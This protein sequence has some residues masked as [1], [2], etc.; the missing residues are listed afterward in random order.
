MLCSECVV[1]AS[2][3]VLLLFIVDLFVSNPEG[4]Q[5]SEVLVLSEARLFC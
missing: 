2:V 5:A 4:D 1:L 3:G